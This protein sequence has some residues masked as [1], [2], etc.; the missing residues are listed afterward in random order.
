ME[1]LW[2]SVIV[3][4]VRDKRV[5]GCL[6]LNSLKSAE[7]SLRYAIEWTSCGLTEFKLSNGGFIKEMG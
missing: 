3:V 4:I 5:W 7:R 1:L 6:S 2:E